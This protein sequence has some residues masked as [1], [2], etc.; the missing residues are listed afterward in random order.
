MLGNCMIETVVLD[1]GLELIRV[2]CACAVYIPEGGGVPALWDLSAIATDCQVSL[3]EG[4]RSQ[5]IDSFGPHAPI[6]N[7]ND[8]D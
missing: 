4:E 5:S 7:E 6:E 2:C 8:D 3:G 1:C